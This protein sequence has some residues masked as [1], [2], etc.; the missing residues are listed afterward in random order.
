MQRL[1]CVRAGRQGD[2]PARQDPKRQQ[3]PGAR[4]HRRLRWGRGGEAL[5]AKND[6]LREFLKKLSFCEFR[7]LIY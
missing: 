1:V 4:L 2:S 3:G 5:A 6:L 7:F